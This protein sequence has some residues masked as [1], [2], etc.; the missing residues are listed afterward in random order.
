[1]S[2]RKRAAEQQAFL[3]ELAALWP[4]ARG[5]LAE[6]RKPCIRPD[7]RACREGR[8][9]KAIIFGF[10]QGGKRRC[11]YVPADLAPVLR[12]A[13]ANGRRLE[14][15]LADLGADLIDRYRKNRS[16]NRE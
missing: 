14:G 10:T 6:V 3:D 8:K 2:K 13:L 15:R 5:S 4:L 11:R 16:R 9:H 7:C 1:M 12:Q